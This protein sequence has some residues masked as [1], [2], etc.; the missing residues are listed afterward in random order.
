MSRRFA[1]EPVCEDIAVP[2]LP[3]FLLARRA[4]P[5]GVLLTAYDIWRRIPRRQRERIVEAT[6]KHGPRL[7]ADAVR[8]RRERA[9]RIGPKP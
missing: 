4:G 8:R 1:L 9:S 7:A 6:R 3:L 5:L 2:R